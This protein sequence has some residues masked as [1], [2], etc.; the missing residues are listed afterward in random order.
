MQGGQETSLKPEG[1]GGK[2]GSLAG[3]SLASIVMVIYDSCV[4]LAW[5]FNLSLTVLVS[6]IYLHSCWNNTRGKA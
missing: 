5:P 2:R 1:S 6:D 4:T 3:V